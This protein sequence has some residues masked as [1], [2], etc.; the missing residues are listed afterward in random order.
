MAAEEGK[1]LREL[2]GEWDALIKRNKRIL[3]APEFLH[4][5]YNELNRLFPSPEELQ[6]RGVERLSL[7]EALHL[8]LSMEQGAH[9]FFKRYAER[10]NDTRGKVHLSEVCRGRVGAL[11]SDSAGVRSPAGSV[12]SSLPSLKSLGSALKGRCDLPPGGHGLFLKQSSNPGPHFS[13]GR[14]IHDERPFIFQQLG[15]PMGTPCGD[16]R[17]WARLGWCFFPLA[18]PCSLDRS[19][20]YALRS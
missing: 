1:H 14:W 12:Q 18:H 16:T 20:R 2:E 13:A 7:E 4:F 6:K 3:K 17:R 10:F 15:G 5:D 8:A 19:D 9:S 11:R